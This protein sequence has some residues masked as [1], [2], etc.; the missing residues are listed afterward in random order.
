MA[1]SPT[2]SHDTP[3]D[4]REAAS[5]AVEIE[6]RKWAIERSASIV[7][8][9]YRSADEIIVDAVKLVAFVEGG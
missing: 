7:G 4:R 8:G 2:T 9:Q 3:A 6:I 5:A 1:N